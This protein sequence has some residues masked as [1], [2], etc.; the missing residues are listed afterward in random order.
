MRPE[1]GA[2]VSAVRRD[3][4]STASASSQILQHEHLGTLSM[5]E[6]ASTPNSTLFANKQQLERW[7]RSFS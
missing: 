2:V 7:N 3:E 5:G 4:S 6:K 1:C